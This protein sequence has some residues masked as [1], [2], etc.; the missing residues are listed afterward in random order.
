MRIERCAREVLL[1]V[2]FGAAG[3]GFPHAFFRDPDNWSSPGGH[4]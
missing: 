3:T 1:P 2:L 4:Q